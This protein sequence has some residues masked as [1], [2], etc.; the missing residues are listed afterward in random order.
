MIFPQL[1][2]LLLHLVSYNSTFVSLTRATKIFLSVLLGNAVYELIVV[3]CQY[4]TCM[5]CMFPLKWDVALYKYLTKLIFI[6][7]NKCIV[8]QKDSNCIFLFG[9]CKY[10]FVEVMFNCCCWC[11]SEP[12]LT[13][14]KVKLL[15]VKTDGDTVCLNT[16][17]VPFIYCK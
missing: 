9:N 15:I 11:V 3:I 7:N 10:V 17:C 6:V 2:C 4:W 16:I 8:V 12:L 1:K 13:F 5:E 14:V